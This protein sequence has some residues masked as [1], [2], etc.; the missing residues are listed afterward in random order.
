MNDLTTS[1]KMAVF[2]G[3]ALLVDSFLP[4]YG[5]SAGF[6]SFNLNAWDVGFLGWG[7]VL[8]VAAGA[9]VVYLKAS[10]TRDVEIG[11]MAPE[12]LAFV[13][14]AMGAVLILLRLLTQSSLARIGLFL[15][16]VLAGVAAYGAF[17]N[18]RDAGLEIPGSDVLD[19]LR[20]GDDD[21]DDS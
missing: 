14:S 17:Q 3:A 13:L 8:L 10:G 11:S 21:D 12:Q 15:G 7:G 16:V 5:F 9:V 1:Q 6:A 2:G 18:T 19:N 4:W 20:G